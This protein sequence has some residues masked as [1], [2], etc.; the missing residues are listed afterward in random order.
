[1]QLGGTMEIGPYKLLLQSF[2]SKPEPNYTSQRM[3]VEVWR[4]DKPLMMLYPERRFFQSNGH[5]SS[6]TE[7]V[8]WPIHS[9]TPRSL[10]TVAG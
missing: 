8:A 6:R 1:M 2:D 9:S 3:I 4:N 10:A 5:T 7:V